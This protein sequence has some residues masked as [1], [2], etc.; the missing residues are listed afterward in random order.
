MGIRVLSSTQLGLAVVVLEG[1]VEGDEFAQ[2]VVPL[3][4]DPGLG[5][6]PKALV[7]ATRAEGTSIESAL[8]HDAAHKARA[9][10]DPHLPQPDSKLAIVAS[11]D[12]FFGLGRMYEMLR[13]NSKVEIHVF[14]QLDEA[15]RWLELPAGY[16]DQ[17]EKVYP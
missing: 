12:E 13:G 17:L 3:I 10:V 15:E 6:L 2:S 14:R 7:D 9:D 5:L 16:G 11:S 4:G 8:L 1:F